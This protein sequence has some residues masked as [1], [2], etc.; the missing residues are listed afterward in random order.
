[1]CDV[2]KTM[3][4]PLL[5]LSWPLMS[6]PSMPDILAEWWARLLGWVRLWV[7]EALGG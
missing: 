6:M 5:L 3:A 2:V 4:M 7:G 1:V